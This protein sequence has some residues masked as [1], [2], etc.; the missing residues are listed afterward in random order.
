M[1]AR[2]DAA[3]DPSDRIKALEDYVRSLRW[4]VKNEIAKVRVGIGDSSNIAEAASNLANAEVEL[5]KLRSGAAK[6]VVAAQPG[7]L[8][9]EDEEDLAHDEA[10][11]KKLSMPIAMPF[12]NETPLSQ[13]IKYIKDST[14]DPGMEQGLPIYVDPQGLQEAEKTMDSPIT[15]SMDQVRLKTS[16]RLILKQLEMGYYIREGMVI[17]TYL[18][19]EDYLDAVYPNRAKPGAIGGMMGGGMG[20]MSGGGMMGGGGLGGGG[21]GFSGGAG[22]PPATPK[23]GGGKP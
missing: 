4:M 16:L 14:T 6:T 21:G 13:V 9:Q 12:P 1:E 19:A 22:N 3:T 20:G 23:G 18:R 11:R 10:I 7:G 8:V 17:I 15:F 2:Y 5:A